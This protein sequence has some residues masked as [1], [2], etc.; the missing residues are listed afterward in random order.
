MR[1]R[2]LPLFV[3]L[4]LLVGSCTISKKAHQERLYLQGIDSLLVRAVKF[5]EPIIQKGDLLTIMVY[6]DNKEATDIFNQQQTG[7]AS[8]NAAVTGG[9]GNIASSGRGYQV[10]LNG[11]IYVHNLG[12]IMVEGKTRKQV[13]DL[14]EVGLKP[15][16]NNAYVT[17]RYTNK[18]ITILGE[19]GKPNVLELPDQQVSIL[20]AIS[21]SGDLTVYGRRDNIL[22]VREENGIR[23]S[24]RLNL[25]DPEIYNSPFFYLQQNDL[26]YIE[27]NQRKSAGN[28]QIFVRNI[29]LAASLL[30]IIT[31]TISLLTR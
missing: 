29:S 11:K 19:V 18:R 2:N 6:S 8:G 17:V 1:I 30:S 26:I 24:S 3:C 31:V 21:L 14:I 27:P 7:G 9:A 20:D 4:A 16:L 28:D 25:R 15:Y 23:K 12:N 13:A 22:V 10:D 5:P